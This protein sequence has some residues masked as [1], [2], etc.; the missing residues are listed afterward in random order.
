MSEARGEL[1]REERNQ[2]PERVQHPVRG[3]LLQTEDPQHQQLDAALPDEAGV[4]LVYQVADDPVDAVVLPVSVYLVREHEQDGL[5]GEVDG[6]GEE[7]VLLRGRG[8]QRPP[9]PRRAGVVGKLE[10]KK[11][12]VEYVKNK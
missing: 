6:G 12:I 3:A 7:L 2:T 8:L 9:L 11:C 1:G 10:S 5:H 4:V